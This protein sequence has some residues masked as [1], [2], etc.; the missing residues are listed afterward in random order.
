MQCGCIPAHAPALTGA[1]AKTTDWV[2]GFH[3]RGVF[4]RSSGSW[5]A[6]M[7]VLA[8]VARGEGPLPGL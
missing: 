5:K 1:R 7:E 6:T 3:A 8:S 4:P 2:G